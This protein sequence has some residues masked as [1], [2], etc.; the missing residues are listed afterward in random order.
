MF[1]SVVAAVLAVALL[2]DALSHGGGFYASVGGLFRGRSVCRRAMESIQGLCHN[3]LYVPVGW[4]GGPTAERKTVYPI[5]GDRTA[6]KLSK[7]P[8]FAQKGSE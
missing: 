6:L 4:A 2:A 8:G 1:R 7:T 5:R 3:G